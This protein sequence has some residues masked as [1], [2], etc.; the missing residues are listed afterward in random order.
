MKF[1][2]TGIK[3]LIRIVTVVVV[4]AALCFALW[5]VISIGLTIKFVNFCVAALMIISVVSF[6]FLARWAWSNKE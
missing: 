2:I 5:E 6:V 1:I 3:Y 4:V